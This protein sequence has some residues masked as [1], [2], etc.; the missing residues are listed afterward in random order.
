MV[1][2]VA[3]ECPTDRN[4]YDNGLFECLTVFVSHTECWQLFDI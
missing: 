2:D 4:I 3:V 1:L